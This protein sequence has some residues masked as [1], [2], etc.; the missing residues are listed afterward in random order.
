MKSR[1]ITQESL[2]DVAWDDE[3]FKFCEFKN[4]SID[5]ESVSS[6]F[7]TCNFIELDWYWGFFTLA[8]FIQC[9]F[10]NCTFRG[11]SFSGARFYECE[12]TNCH[13]VKDNLDGECCFDDALAYGCKVTK[14]E[15]FNVPSLCPA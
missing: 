1:L 2:S 6:D 10:E 4:F 3:Y 15:G 12:F 13:F 5:M 9:K 8:N 7:V 11:S 14:C